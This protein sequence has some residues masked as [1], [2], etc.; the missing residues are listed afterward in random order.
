ME[1]QTCE[2]GKNMLKLKPQPA[3][4]ELLS[5]TA[6]SRMLNVGRQLVYAMIG[7]GE[8]ARRGQGWQLVACP[9]VEPVPLG[10]ARCLLW[11]GNG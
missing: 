3:A 11:R 2:K 6:V 5:V 7:Q 4:E 1:T 8:P 10:S 9:A